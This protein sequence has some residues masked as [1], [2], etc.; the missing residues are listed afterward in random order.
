MGFFDDPINVEKYVD[1][2]EGYDFTPLSKELQRVLPEGSSLLEIGMG[3]GKDLITLSSH[4]NVTGSDNS[5]VFVDRFRKE[6]PETPIP[7]LQLDARTLEINQK[8]DCIYS[9]KVL[10][11]LEPK[12]M[13]TSL[14]RQSELLK[15]GGILFMTLWYGD[16][17]EEFDGLQF[18]YYNEESVKKIVP[19]ELSIREIKKY[20]EMEE[21]DS[22]ILLLEKV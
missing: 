8:F 9:N 6:Y 7:V 22:F 3:P 10:M 11:H 12:E 18:N 13:I 16:T 21:G 19:K 15:S 2:V 20:S 17:R 1:M 14:K 5:A 4:Y